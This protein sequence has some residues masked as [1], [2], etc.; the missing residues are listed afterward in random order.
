MPVVWLRLPQ[1]R[2][3]EIFVEVRPRSCPYC[4]GQILQRWGRITKPIK[5]VQED[6]L[7]LYRYRCGNCGR[8]FRD[9][10]D[11]TDRAD[12]TQRIRQIAGLAWA[13]GMSCR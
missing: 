4:G 11:G 10:P 9:Y 7:V 6:Q 13:M 5:D 12:H 8:T 3:E 1:I 2:D